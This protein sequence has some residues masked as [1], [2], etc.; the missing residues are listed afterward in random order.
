MAKIKNK[1]PITVSW[2]ESEKRELYLDSLVKEHQWTVGIE[3]GVRF[4]RTLFYLLENNPTLKM[5]AVDIDIS[6][7]YNQQVKERYGDRLIVLEGDSATLASTI[8]ETVDFVF[9]DGAHS[10]KAVIKDIT[11][12]RKILKSDIGL[13]GHDIDYPSIQSALDELGIDYNVCPDNV[14]T[15]KSARFS[16]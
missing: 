6:Q 5:Y 16:N 11:E 12:Y 1:L 10:K 14:W 4:G 15:F 3:V 2:N 7:F 8:K 13:T 9:I